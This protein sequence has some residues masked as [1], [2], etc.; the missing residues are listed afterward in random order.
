MRHGRMRVRPV[1]P[2]PTGTGSSVSIADCHC[3]R[4]SSKYLLSTMY[5]SASSGVPLTTT[6]RF[7]TAFL[8]TEL[9]SRF[10]SE[11]DFDDLWQLHDRLLLKCTDL[12]QIRTS[13]KVSGQRRTWHMDYRKSFIRG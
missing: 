3:F 10:N 13:A 7:P 5:L 8:R 9:W 12:S 11:I 4:S 6:T 2:S 1:Y